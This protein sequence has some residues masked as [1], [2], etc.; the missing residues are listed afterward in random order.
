MRVRLLIALV[1]AAIACGLWAE[2]L[3]LEPIALPTGAF[4]SLL[5]P[6]LELGSHV[7]RVGPT[8]R[9]LCIDDRGPVELGLGAF[10][11]EKLAARELGIPGPG[12]TFSFGLDGLVGF[13][14]AGDAMPP[15]PW[16]DFPL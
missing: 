12:S 9:S 7:D 8:I 10:V 14:T 1:L 6:G 11:S 4:R 16:T 2:P 5:Y 13:G 15:A 3:P